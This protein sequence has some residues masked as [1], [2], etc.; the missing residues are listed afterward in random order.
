M[1]KFELGDLQA[2]A[3]LKARNVPQL[4][5][6]I[7]RG[8]DIVAPIP[9]CVLMFKQELPLMFPDDA[10][11]AK[12]KEQH[13]RSVRVS[14]PAAQ[15]GRV[16]HG[17]QAAA[18]QDRLSRRMPPARAESRPQDPRHPAARSR[19]RRVEP[20]ERCSGHDGTYGVKREF[21]ETSMK[22]AKP[23]IQR[24]ESSGA[25]FYSSDCPMAG[26]QIESGLSRDTRARPSTDPAQNGL[27]PI[28]GSHAKAITRGLDAAR[29]IFARAVAPAQR[30]HRAQAAPQ[31][32]SRPE[33]DLVLR[34][35]DHHPLSG[36]R[37]AARRAHLRARRHSGRAGCLQ[38]AD[39]R[40]Q[41]LEGDAAA[42][43]S[44]PGRAPG[45]S[46]RS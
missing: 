25:D 30:G 26:H 10:D 17:F 28:G 19:T 43:I 44:R 46:L 39:P 1:P 3:D 12:V 4:M 35:P 29:A 8:Y 31:R 24:V 32:P 37:D 16:A 41:Q 9:S 6:M 5:A 45:S 34:G 27:R 7:D 23:V 42:R 13:L 22:I 36:A 21:R 14:R 15:G 40:R 33:H 2:V 11:V 38:P 20:I 18:G